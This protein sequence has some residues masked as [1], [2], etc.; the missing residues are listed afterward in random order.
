MN[1]FDLILKFSFDAA[2]YLP[3]YIGKCRDMHGHTWAVEVIIQGAGFGEWN[4][5][6][7][8]ELKI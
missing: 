2:H 1:K 8:K 5:F 7:F 4:G 3:N 6:D